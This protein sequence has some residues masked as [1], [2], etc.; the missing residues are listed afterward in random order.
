MEDQLILLDTNVLIQYFRTKDKKKTFLH[1]LALENPNFAIS[2]ITHFE[3]LRGVN[4]VQEEFWWN[5]LKDIEV[6]SYFPAINYT[7]V[8][9][10]KQ[11]KVLRKSINIQDL[12]IAATAVHLQYPLATLNLKHFE[13]IEGISLIEF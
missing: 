5:F 10:Q 7:A 4:E 8:Q 6:M 2:V 11:L 1:Q 9:I 12:I 3:V 13:N